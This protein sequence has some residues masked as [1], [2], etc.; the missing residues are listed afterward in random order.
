MV[1]LKDT[2]AVLVTHRNV[3]LSQIVQTL[4][5]FEEVVVWDNEQGL[6]VGPL[7]R[8]LGAL[9]LTKKRFVYMQDDDCTTIPQEIAG[10]WEPGKIVC[11]MGTAGHAANYENKLDK[12][13]GFG[14]FFERSLIKPTFDRYLQLFSPDQILFREAGRIFT[15]INFKNTKVVEVPVKN[16]P[17][18]EGD[19]RMYRQPGHL[20]AH[21]KAL[22]MVQTILD[23]ENGG[24]V[25]E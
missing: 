3:D 7:G 13:M 4:D 5:C 8:F 20:G 24:K 1:K 18:A 9:H 10:A 22:R 23:L 14:S 17:W 2:A 12:L 6:N 25:I 15:A 11:N 16:L 21:A 19:D